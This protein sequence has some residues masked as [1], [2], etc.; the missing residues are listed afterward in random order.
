VPEG[1]ITDEDIDR[2]KRGLALYNEQSFDALREFIAP[3]VIVER[4]GEM[5]PLEGW[6]AF[7]ELLEPDAFAWQRM[8]PLDWTINGG[9]ALL[10]VRLHA[11]GAGSGIELDMDGWQVWTVREGLVSRI[12]AFTEEAPAR[13]AAGLA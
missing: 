4:P 1:P 2:M 10:H 11:Q 3:D 13:E 8:H 6:D 7:R 5:P 9:K 12:Q